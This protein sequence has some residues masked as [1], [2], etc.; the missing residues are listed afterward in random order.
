MSTELVVGI[1]SRESPD[2]MTSPTTVQKWAVVR[3][4]DYGWKE[5]NVQSNR[6]CAALSRSVRLTAGLDLRPRHFDISVALHGYHSGFHRRH[7][8]L[9]NLLA[10]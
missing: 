6:R 8:A 10:Q 1:G 9:R 7:S 5:S 2:H 3:I 4:E